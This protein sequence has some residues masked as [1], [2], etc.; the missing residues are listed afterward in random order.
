MMQIEAP[1]LAKAA[2]NCNSL[3]LP[4]P[5]SSSTLPNAARSLVMRRRR[6]RLHLPPVSTPRYAR[7][8][9]QEGCHPWK[10]KFETEGVAVFRAQPGLLAGRRCNPDL[11]FSKVALKGLD[12]ARDSATQWVAAFDSRLTAT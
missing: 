3:H 10:D 8:S 12:K 7:Y 4:P 2:G 9:I 1:A 5:R 11:I 6:G